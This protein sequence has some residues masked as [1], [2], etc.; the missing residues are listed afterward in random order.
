MGALPAPLT[1]IQLWGRRPRLQAVETEGAEA[2]GFLKDMGALARSRNPQSLNER[3][4]FTRLQA[5][6]RRRA[7]VVN[8]DGGERHAVLRLAASD[9]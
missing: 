1:G 4:Q 7:C 6:L 9:I 5:S 8:T 2:A 3:R